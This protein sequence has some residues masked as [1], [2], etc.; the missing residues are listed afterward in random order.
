MREPFISED[1]KK[2]IAVDFDGTLCFNQYPIIN[3]P[4][5]QLIEFIKKHRKKYVWIL[6]T[7][8]HDEQL[9]YALEWLKE[10]GIVFD[11]VNENIP[12]MIERYGETRKIWADYYID[13]KSLRP[14][15]F[16]YLKGG[17]I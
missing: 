5:T 4:N 14:D 10:Q 6:W 15:E 17:R 7:C 2:V 3:N 16:S 9:E 13:D 8:R 12:K 1:T 11:Y